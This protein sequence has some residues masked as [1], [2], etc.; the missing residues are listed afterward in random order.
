MDN[1]DNNSIRDTEN[2]TIRPLGLILQEAGLVSSAQIQVALLDQM[3][4][5]HLLLGEILALHGWLKQETAD[6]FAVNWPKLLEQEQ[7][8]RLGE[9]LKKAGL[10]TDEQVY[11]ILKEQEKTLM[12]FGALAVIKGYLR[13][14][15]IEFFLRNLYPDQQKESA[16]LVN[17][18]TEKTDNDSKIIIPNSSQII[19]VSSV[20]EELNDDD[21]DEKETN[22]LDEYLQGKDIIWIA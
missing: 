13:K 16:F 17:K 12:R 18:T 10:L 7:K 3:E 5:D 11:N 1:N 14:N 2:E 21:F 20:K 6:F 8:Q 9:Y 4:N 19:T 22:I 15:T